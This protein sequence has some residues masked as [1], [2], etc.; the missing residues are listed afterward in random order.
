MTGNWV[1]VVVL[2]A[3]IGHALRWVPGNATMRS[4]KIPATFALLYV[5]YAAALA[6]TGL[7]GILVAIVIV[8]VALQITV[9]RRPQPA[10]G[11]RSPGFGKRRG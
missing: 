3:A 7:T 11:T 1:W 8:E 9:R 2:G 10:P 6:M 4:V 5:V